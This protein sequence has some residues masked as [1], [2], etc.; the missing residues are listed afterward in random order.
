MNGIQESVIMGMTWLIKFRGGGWVGQNIA[1]VLGTLGYVGVGLER[2]EDCFEPVLNVHTPL[3][4]P[5][6]PKFSFI[7]P[8]FQLVN[9]N[10]IILSLCLCG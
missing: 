2:G 10:K 5:F 8:P 7:A 9:Q 1:W 4:S 6:S 3:S